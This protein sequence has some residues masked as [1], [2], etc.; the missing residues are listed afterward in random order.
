MIG[1]ILSAGAS[2]AVG[3]AK[4][5]WNLGKIGTFELLKEGGLA[6]SLGGAVGQVA[7]AGIRTAGFMS[8][9]PGLT[10]TAGIMGGA[11]Y[12]GYGLNK[13]MN[14]S[15]RDFDPRD[16][17]VVPLQAQSRFQNSA[18]GL[19]FGLHARRHNS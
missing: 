7:S 16:R 13:N 9:N 8:R 3:T 10:M 6:R 2:A 12:H 19:V 4:L 5:G 15:R 17:S 14:L 18:A 11:A 1:R